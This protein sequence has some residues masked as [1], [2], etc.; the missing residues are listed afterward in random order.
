VA[1]DG[2][3]LTVVL[4]KA[5]WVVAALWAV[6]LSVQAA[7]GV[8]SAHE[9][10]VRRAIILAATALAFAVATR[11]GV[12]ASELAGGWD[13]APE[14]AGLVFEMQQPSILTSASAVC[15][16]TAGAAFRSRV[17]LA[18]GAILAGLAF[19]MTGHARS[20]DIPWL[21]AGIVGLHVVLAGFWACAPLTLWP[22]GSLSSAEL[23]VRN[24]RF[25]QIALMA[26]PVLLVAGAVMA[27]M[28]G[29]GTAGLIGSA[30]GAMIAI[31][32]TCT[33]GALGIGG[34]NRLVLAG[35]LET[36][37]SDA[38]AL[39]ARAM[40][41]D[42]VLFAGAIIAVVLATTIAAPGS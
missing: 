36:E 30:Y 35:A 27:W 8:V 38:R 15:L 11:F 13:G 25:G 31:K 20:Q 42:A 40:T 41:I 12:T 9:A 10:P 3:A 33:M 37:A 14:L 21:A 1:V 23:A 28:F 2:L 16:L 22:A 17:L 18:S 5:G 29:G 7:C 39:L 34:W 32:V 4:A 6:G 26:V 24:R 19:G